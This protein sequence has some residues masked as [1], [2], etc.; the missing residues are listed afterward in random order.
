MLLLNI[1]LD[2]YF[3]LLYV[4]KPNI[5]VY[6]ENLICGVFIKYLTRTYHYSLVTAIVI[7][8]YSFNMWPYFAHILNVITVS[9]LVNFSS[10]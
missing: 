8:I 7:S 1:V 4:L 6:L 3:S 5:R 9:Q 10:S 2:L